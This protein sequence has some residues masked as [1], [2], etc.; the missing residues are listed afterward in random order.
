[1]QDKKITIITE[2]GD[3]SQRIMEVNAGLS[4][5]LASRDVEYN[6]ERDLVRLVKSERHKNS[7]VYH[8]EILKGDY[9]YHL[10]SRQSCADEKETKVREWVLRPAERSDLPDFAFC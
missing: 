1:M 5:W 2:T 7:Y 3:L 4:K 8:Y 9:L 10:A 6:S